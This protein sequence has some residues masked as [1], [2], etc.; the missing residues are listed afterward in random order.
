[1]KQN[2]NRKKDIRYILEYAKWQ[3]TPPLQRNHQL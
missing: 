2:K 3:Q 1:M